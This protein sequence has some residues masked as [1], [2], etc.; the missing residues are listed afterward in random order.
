MTNFLSKIYFP[1]LLTV[2]LFMISSIVGIISLSI[3]L[4]I[5]FG[6][7]NMPILKVITIIVFLIINVLISIG[8]VDIYH[9]IEHTE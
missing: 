4:M 1:S 3:L 2:I 8:C 9:L 6:V 7:I 5:L